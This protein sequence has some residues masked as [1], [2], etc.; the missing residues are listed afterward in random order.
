MS[1]QE[2]VEVSYDVGNEFFRLWLDE[3]MNY[4]CGIYEGTDNLE[5][6]Q[7]KKLEWLAD[8]AHVTPEKRV[9][10]IGCGWG[11]DVEH[12]VTQ[13]NAKS[14]TGITLS[15]SQAE[16]CRRR[17]LPRA[18]FIVTD[19][20]DFAPQEKFDAVISICMMEH[21]ATPE[22]VR[23]G[24]HIGMYRDY[25]RRAWEWTNPGSYFGLQTILRNKV[26]RIKEDLIDINWLTYAIFPGGLSLRLED[27][28][29]AV[30]PYWEIMEIKTRRVDYQKTT[31]EWLRRMRL[32][33]DYIR[34]TWGDVVFDDYDR[35]LRTCV[36]GFDMHYQSLAQYS[37]RRID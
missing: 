5:E 30:N 23:E 25:F 1:N 15:R 20:R 17:E 2:E 10:D 8:A 7:V 29:K 36:R 4:T 12:L 3:K 11:A 16:E 26:P 19:Y 13:R 14:A 35:Y 34:K 28:V 21:I 27:I 37:L 9:L 18:E 6:A 31:A 32:H 22:Q 24:K 33:E